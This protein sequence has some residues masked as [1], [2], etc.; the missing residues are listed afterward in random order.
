MKKHRRQRRSQPGT[1][2]L[3]LS[4]PVYLPDMRQ[5]Q[6]NIFSYKPVDN[7]QGPLLVGMILVEEF[8]QTDHMRQCCERLLYGDHRVGK[9]FVHFEG[10]ELG[11]FNA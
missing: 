9:A 3:A 1:R 2:S 4:D 7:F 6:L 10:K 11:L 5:H 8:G